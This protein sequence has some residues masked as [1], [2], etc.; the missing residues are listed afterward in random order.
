MVPVLQ[1]Q[2]QPEQRFDVDQQL[3]GLAL[4]V[5]LERGAEGGTAA[6]GVGAAVGAD[7]VHIDDLAR[8][9]HAAAL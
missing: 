6:A 1:L 5:D 4:R 9:G 2:H 3:L 8:C 7:D